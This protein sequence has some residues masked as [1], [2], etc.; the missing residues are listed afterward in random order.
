MKFK[1]VKHV[2]ISLINNLELTK[3]YVVGQRL[4]NSNKKG[5]VGCKYEFIWLLIKSQLIAKI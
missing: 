2:S 5:E 4:I 3:E 1:F